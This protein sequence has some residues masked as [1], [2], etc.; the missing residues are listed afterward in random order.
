[1]SQSGP[2]IIVEDDQD[3]QEIIQEALRENGITN[4]MI[5]FDQCNKAFH[6]LKHT[7]DPIFLILS[8]V[9]LP[10][11]NGVEFKRQIDADTELRSKSIPFVFF[12]TSVD[13]KAVNTAYKEMTVQGFFKKQESYKELKQV[14]KVIMD[15]WKL[16][17][18]PNS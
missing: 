8:D 14:L 2:I 15:Y 3:D 13:K 11:Q 9:N 16:C 1:M 7:D 12:S 4:K 10:A 6:Y 5:F 17:Y 18:H